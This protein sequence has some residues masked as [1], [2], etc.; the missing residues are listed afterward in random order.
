MLHQDDYE[1]ILIDKRPNGVAVATRNRPEK[2]NAVNGV[3]HNE[4]SRLFLDAEADAEI[5]VVL[6]V[7]AGR[8]FCAGGD[9]GGGSPPGGGDGRNMMRE[10]AT[11]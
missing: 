1:T 11:K 2:L 5:R 10:A 6:L 8:A 4:L 7:A 9:F 3:M